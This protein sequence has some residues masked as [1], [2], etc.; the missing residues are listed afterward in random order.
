MS[1]STSRCAANRRTTNFQSTSDSVLSDRTGR[2]RSAVTGRWEPNGGVSGAAVVES[3][4]KEFEDTEK[5][6]ESGAGG[7]VQGYRWLATICWSWR[8]RLLNGR[9]GESGLTLRL[10][11]ISPA[12]RAWWSLG[13]HFFFELAHSGGTPGPNATWSAFCF[14]RD[15]PFTWSR[16]IL[17]TGR[18]AP[19]GDG[20][21]ARRKDLEGDGQ[22]PER[23]Q[24]L[25]SN[26]KGRDPDD[27]AT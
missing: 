11:T 27:G 8:P 5:N 23:D 2:R 19:R 3:E 1:A 26:L 10:P 15:S 14:K 18:A 22:A 9:M 24:I 20:G 16:R 21:R 7:L 4:A 25:L 17:E 13:R 6:A 12:T